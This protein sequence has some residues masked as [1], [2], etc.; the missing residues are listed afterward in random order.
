MKMLSSLIASAIFFALGCYSV[1]Y[2][3][4]LTRLARERRLNVFADY[5]SGTKEEI[6]LGV[7]LGLA[8]S[9]AIFFYSM[10]LFFILT[11]A[12]ISLEL[13]F[14]IAISILTLGGIILFILG[15]V[16]AGDKRTRK[17]YLGFRKETLPLFLSDLII[18]VLMFFLF[19]IT[20]HPVR[21]LFLFM[22]LLMAMIGLI[23]VTLKSKKVSG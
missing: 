14:L 12:N 16:K 9:A 19:W 22:G 17:V 18:A 13:A 15:F 1:K 3:L 20:N 8:Y 2:C 23:G 11:A 10:F 6:D 4:K 21:W 5:K 7:K